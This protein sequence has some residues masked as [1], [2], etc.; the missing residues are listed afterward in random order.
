M[1]GL[2]TYA[3]FWQHSAPFRPAL[4]LPDMLRMT[5]EQGAELFQIC[6]YAPVENMIDDQL[7][8]IRNLADDLDLTLELGTRGLGSEH[9]SNYLRLADLLGAGLVRSMVNTATHQPTLDEAA[10]LLRDILP[11]YEK[12]GVTLAL[13]TYE[14][15]A[16]ADLVELVEGA[17]SPNLGI[18][19]DPANTVARLEHPRDVIDRTAEHVVNI[20][21]KDFTF[22]R[23]D[24]WV[25]F[26]L[27]GCP[28]GEGML[29]YD[30]LLDRV[31][32]DERGINQ[33]IEHWLPMLATVDKTIE[34]EQAWTA[35]NLTYLAEHTLT[36]I[37]SN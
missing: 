10:G 4:A 35:H 29:P 15:V 6:D 8:G 28:L 5:H 37:R 11:S 25:G 23:K 14:Q 2:S 1:I 3:F 9:L 12:A 32:P 22:S 16:T 36:S 27:V 21:V 24:G 13:E 17:G 30:Y 26:S 20:H 18:C 7:V 31:R 19:L 33:V 34:A